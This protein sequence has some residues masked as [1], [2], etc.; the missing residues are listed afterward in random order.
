MVRLGLDVAQ[1]QLEWDEILERVRLA[2]KA[3]FDGAWVFDHFKALYG[4]PGGP[5][6]EGW[7][8]L[9]ALGGATERIRL[10]SLVTGVTYRH[11]SILAAQ[12]VTVDHVSRGR[13]EMSFGAA[14][15]E[16]EHR[17]L[18]VA[19]PGRRE[20]AERLEEAI[21]V[22]R[23]LLTE[24]RVS[25]EGRHYRLREATYRPRPIQQPHPPVWVGAGGERLMLPVVGRHAD[26]WHGFGSV[27]ELRRKSRIVDEHARAAGRN[28]AAILRSTSL[29]LS[30]PWDEVRRRTEALASEG[31]S[32]FVVGWPSEGRGRLE[33]FIEDVMPELSSLP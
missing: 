26:A 21:Q 30:Q 3:G 33:E 17:E 27:S 29:S 22:F 24:D 20:R 16:R 12:A 4:D 8:L 14:W 19:F 15:V 32:Y 9:A 2:E 23:L 13:L 6:L 11:P 18:G 5:C 1:H 7:S 31:F 25:F 10:G 28:P